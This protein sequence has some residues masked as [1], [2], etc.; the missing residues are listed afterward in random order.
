MPYFEGIFVRVSPADYSVT[1]LGMLKYAR[2]PHA[3]NSVLLVG[4]LIT[5]RIKLYHLCSIPI[6]DISSRIISLFGTT[7]V[8]VYYLSL[9]YCVTYM[10]AIPK[11]FSVSS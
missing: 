11:Y 9:I 7:Y 10:L 5:S 3:F 1:A 2:I 6:V 8:I 4:D